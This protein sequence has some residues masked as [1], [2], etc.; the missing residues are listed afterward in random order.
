M[1]VTKYIQSLLLDNSNTVFIGNKHEAIQ[2]Y[3]DGETTFGATAQYG[4]QSA[5]SALDSLSKA[6]R[7]TAEYTSI[8]DGGTTFDVPNLTRV[9][10][11]GSSVNAL[12]FSMYFI[13]QNEGEDLMLPVKAA[14][15]MVLPEINK[16]G[17]LGAFSTP[18]GYNANQSGDQ[19]E[20]HLD[21]RIG[22]WFD[23]HGFVMNSCTYTIS[24]EKI[25]DAGKL[26]LYIKLDVTLMPTQVFS[27]SVVTSWFK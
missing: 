3:V 26:P 20:N 4:R 19:T 14:F 25:D 6:V 27:A 17:V 23:A 16:A 13:A 15:K 21:V 8:I 1:T 11:E 24:K 9:S 2:G 10:W 12:S 18:L 7:Q 22:S 5:S